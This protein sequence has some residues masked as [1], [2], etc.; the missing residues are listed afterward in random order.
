MQLKDVIIELSSVAG[1]SGSEGAAAKRVSELLEPYMDDVKT[2]NLGNVIGYKC[3][4]KKGVKKLL[5]DAHIDEVG[6]IVT[7]V[8]EGFLKF[9]AIGSIDPMILPAREVNILTNPPLF[10]VI[11]CMPVHALTPEDMNKPSKTEDMFIDIGMGQ[12]ES[13]K[14]VPLGTP[15]VFNTRCGSLQGDVLTGKA[16]DNRACMAIILNALSLLKGKELNVDLI[17]MGSVQEELGH[18]GAMTGAFAT[19]PDYAVA[20][21]VTHAKTP[22]YKKEKALNFGGGAAIGV[23]PNVARK[24]S[25]KLISISKAMGIS[26]QIEPMGGSSGTNAWVMQTSR[27]GIATAVVSL[28]LKYMHTPV[29]TMKLSDAESISR[30]LSEFVLSLKGGEL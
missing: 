16:L 6:L 25:D 13:V 28:P 27:E 1:P 9:S 11:G 18:R 29:E 14:A 4:G 22:D 3:C 5:I 19:A 10:G 24:L 15:I 20:L 8:E 17:V 12:D 30:L 2:D 21:D 7:G 23:G 26:Y